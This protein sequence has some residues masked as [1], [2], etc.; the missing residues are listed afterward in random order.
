MAE[1]VGVAFVSLVPSARGFSKL[2]QRELNAELRGNK[3]P[4]INVRPTV[5]AA[6]ARAE[7]TTQLTGLSRQATVQVGVEVDQQLARQQVT[8]SLVSVSDT[9]RRTEKL[10]VETDVDPVRLLQQTRAAVNFAEASAGDIDV[11]IDAHPER[12]RI[13][14]SLFGAAFG[15]GIDG[16]KS[17]VV[18]ALTAPFRDPKVALIM[19]AALV[20]PLGAA[21]VPAIGAAISAAV[22]GATGLGVIGLGAFL[23][24]DDPEVRKAAGEFGTAA[25]AAFVGAAQPLVQPFV[26]ALGI[27]RDLVVELRPQLTEM[28]TAIAPAILP[29]TRG[30]AGFVRELM[31]GLLA[32][33]KA[34]TP[35]LMDLEQTLPRLGE[36]LSRFFGLIADSGPGATQ[37]FRDFLHLL[38][39]GLVV[40]G[41]LIKVLTGWYG[42]TR[43]IVGKVIEVWQFFQA[44]TGRVVSAVIGFFGRARDFVTGVWRK[45]RSDVGGTIKAIP[46]IV[47]AGVKSFGTLLYGAGGRLIQSLIDGIKSK[48]GALGGVVGS[49]AEKVRGFWP[50]SPAKEGPLSG[51]GSL[52]YAGQ[53]LMTDLTGGMQRKLPAVESAS[54]QL[55]SALGTG[56]R[57]SD[58]AALAP[59]GIT[60]G[61]R[62]GATGDKILD[63]L[64]DLIEFR[65]GGDPDAALASR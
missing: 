8:R 41:G 56:A 24:K 57:G 7:I 40:F 5:D 59:A 45:I 65:F 15:S 6:T 47:L 16:S 28:F 29:L 18:A 20:T 42:H 39:L 55:A 53:N 13:L 63:G 19:A 38:G 2:A 58:G 54:N 64:R 31:P 1:E 46:G 21:L 36:H 52:Y 11:D 27:L 33:V 34:A 26:A 48:F 60:A 4:T 9:V 43:M 10:D 32:L 44:V 61:W 12:G 17:T 25:K 23:L 22:I 35:F 51:R 3:T 49:V 50:F 62:P 14:G 30:F 37:F